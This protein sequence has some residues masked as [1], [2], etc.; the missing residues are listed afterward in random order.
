MILVILM[1]KFNHQKSI[2]SL[3]SLVSYTFSYTSMITR[4]ET[5]KLDRE[6]ID[7][8]LKEWEMG[9]K[10][11]GISSYYKLLSALHQSRFNHS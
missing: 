7:F 8:W 3:K 4:K 6:L 1:I 11:F 2:K 10:Y 9:F 5:N